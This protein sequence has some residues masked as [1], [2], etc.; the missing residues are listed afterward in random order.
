MKCQACG[1][2]IVLAGSKFCSECGV[3][4]EPLKPTPPRCETFTDIR[5]IKVGVGTEF[6]IMPSNTNETTV[7]VDG[8]EEV[9]QGLTMKLQNGVLEING[10]SDSV[11]ISISNT[12]GQGT[13][14][15]GNI[16]IGHGIR[17]V[18]VAGNN[19]V[20]GNNTIGGNNPVSVTITTPYN[21]EV[22][23]DTTGDVNCEVGEI[24]GEISIATDGDLTFN[25]VRLISFKAEVSG[26]L[27]VKIDQF[28]GEKCKIEVDGDCI[29]SIPSGHI[30]KLIIDVCGDVRLEVG[31]ETV[32]AK[33]KIIGDLNGNLRAE[34]AR[35]NVVG[36][37]T[38]RIIR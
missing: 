3:K 26:D 6:K 13:I 4:I 16:F 19:T 30:E 36:L 15:E 2:N 33:I 21:V 28:E 14:I 25:A 10:P 34:T 1:K 22:I 17:N 8:P 29:L 38:V 23:I 24:G 7:T 20:I 37:N 11:N 32:E 9:K 35:M 12:G 5:K 31:A 18:F 27:S